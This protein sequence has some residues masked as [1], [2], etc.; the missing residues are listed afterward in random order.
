VAEWIV[1][2]MQGAGYVG[3]AL[4]MFLENVFP[5][6]P[7]ELIMPLAGYAAA[8]GRLTLAGVIVAG[9]LGSLASTFIWY[10]VGRRVGAQRLRSWCGRSG[11]WLGLS[12]DEVDTA[13]AWFR[14]RSGAAAVLL[15]RLV[16]GV[17]TLIS[18]PA[19]I[20][21]MPLGVFVLCS[22]LGTAAWTAA[23]AVAGYVLTSEF[24]AVERW[25]DPVS[26]AI[27]V[28]AVV[29]YLWRVVRWAPPAGSDGLP[30]ER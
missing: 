15:G 1:D 27:V 24:E 10:E 14:R 26:T 16:P 7:S 4:L 18:V 6:I 28:V 17:R 20:A 2:F 3:I 22:A 23:L 8:D 13:V 9:T 5:P 29:V 25:L 21:H 30:P 19:G 12:P 11:R